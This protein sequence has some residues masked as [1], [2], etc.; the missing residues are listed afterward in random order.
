MGIWMWKSVRVQ[1]TFMGTT[2][3]TENKVQVKD[4]GRGFPQAAATAGA[5]C[6]V[7][8]GWRAQDMVQPSSV[9]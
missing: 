9:I 1:L 4:V 7:S 5:Q 8:W 6:R 2:V 3:G